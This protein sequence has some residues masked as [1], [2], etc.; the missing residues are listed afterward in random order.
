MS[1]WRFYAALLGAKLN[2]DALMPA[3]L[4]VDHVIVGCWGLVGEFG[5]YRRIMGLNNGSIVVRCG[6]AFSKSTLSTI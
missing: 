6:R 4:I 1:E 5:N 3:K 2:S